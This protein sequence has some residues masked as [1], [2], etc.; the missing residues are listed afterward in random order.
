MMIQLTGEVAPINLLF[1]T[2]VE[3]IC[4]FEGAYDYEDID[5]I[6][7]IRVYP[8]KMQSAN[9]EVLLT[10]LHYRL[11]DPLYNSV[12]CEKELP[13]P[14][15]S[16]FRIT[17]SQKQCDKLIEEFFTYNNIEDF[18]PVVYPLTLDG[19]LAKVELIAVGLEEDTIAKLNKQAKQTVIAKKV[20]TRINKVGDILHTSGRIVTNNIA[21]PLAVA[22][23]KTTAT[24][25]SG[26]AKTAV[27][28]AMV[29]TN[30]VLRDV[31]QFS[32][33]EIKQRDEAKTIVYSL[34]KIMNKTNHTSAKQQMNNYS[35]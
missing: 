27:D 25:A 9:L 7:M 16:T 30:E 21:N 13:V 23:T 18:V 4:C 31:A 20:N 33:S 3:P 1:K 12:E 26:L 19:T 32:F 17:A 34:K 22:A 24:I 14:N 35:L 2:V 15:Q 28:C 8:E 6:A 29:A 11:Q 10:S 5:D